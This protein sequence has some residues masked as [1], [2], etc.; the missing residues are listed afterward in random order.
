MK[1]STTGIS[2]IEVLIATT[3]TALLG[4]LLTS[5][6]TSTNNI[7]VN[8]SA[9]VE[10]GLSS[11]QA[12]LEVSNLIKTSAGVALQYPA[13]GTAQYVSSENVLVLKLP[14]FSSTGQVLD[15][16]FD[17]AVIAKDQANSKILRLWVF[18]DSQ[19]SRKPQN[20]VLSTSLKSVQ[21]IY[22]DTTNQQVSPVQA[23]RI[24]YIINLSQGT[25]S[26]NE[27]ILNGTINIKNF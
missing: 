10:Q 5:L 3:L 19:S 16:V 4:F 2:M 20:K 23:V 11:N 13:T 25:N 26:L 17:Y 12:T 18:V 24:N 8:Q 7:F 9:Q 14:A 15:S 1:I 6:L 22:L 27:S 21:F